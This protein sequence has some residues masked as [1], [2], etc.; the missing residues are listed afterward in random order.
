MAPNTLF[1]L[2][3]GTIPNPLAASPELLKNHLELQEGDCRRIGFR[4]SGLGF[5]VKGSRV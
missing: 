1:A 3:G 4:V 2:V 5:R